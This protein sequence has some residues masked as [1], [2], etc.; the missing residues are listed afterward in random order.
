LIK[1]LNDTNAEEITRPIFESIHSSYANSNY[2]SLIGNNF[3]EKMKEDLTEEVFEEAIQKYYSKY[4]GLVEMTFLGYV[5][6]DVGHQVLWKCKYN[7]NTEEVLWH[8]FFSKDNSERHEVV[9]LW[10]G[11]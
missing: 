4:G 6:R 11:Y 3:S 7:E 9:G 5:D 8:V 10:F 2:Q 1:K